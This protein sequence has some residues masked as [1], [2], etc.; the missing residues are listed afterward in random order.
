[1]KPGARG[2]EDLIPVGRAKSPE[3]LSLMTSAAN[4][5][6]HY[7]GTIEIPGIARG[8]ACLLENGK[9]L[10]C[11]HNILD[12]DALDE[13]RAQLID[14]KKHDV[15]VYFVKDDH[16]YKY[17][18]NSAPVTGLNKLKALGARA[19]CF[20]YALLEAEVNPTHD[21]GGGFKPDKTNHFGS[22]FVTD[23]RYTLA[24]SGPFI[25]TTKEGLKFHRFAS[26]S[27]N[28]AAQDGPY[29][30]TQAGDHPSA[31]GFSGMGIVPIDRNYPIDTLYAIHSYR[32]NQG[33]QSGAKVSEIRSS[34]RDEVVAAED[35]RLDLDLIRALKKW[36]EVLTKAKL[37]LDHSVT[38]GEV[39]SFD[40]AVA[41]LTKGGNITGDSKKE[42][43][44]PAYKAWGGSIADPAHTPLGWPHLHHPQ[45]A[46]SG[47]AL[48]P[49]PAQRAEIAERERQAKL[50]EERRLRQIA[51]AAAKKPAPSATEP[52]AENLGIGRGGVDRL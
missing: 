1:M 47:H 18:I 50:A 9:I 32:D 28:Q 36:Y 45:R 13:R 2:N 11:L 46:I 26:L 31:P 48:Y 40:E 17:R 25:T 16:I 8:T 4:R 23:P 52:R 15:S 39:I 35:S 37:N 42:V 34:M 5:V 27:E 29:H 19:W 38:K 22:A 30:V 10:T 24:V 33:Q 20:D 43:T 12:Y 21:L 3:Q 7:I 49:G 51:E 44:S 6:K 41:I 14:F